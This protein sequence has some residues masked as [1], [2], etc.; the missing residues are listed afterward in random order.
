MSRRNYHCYL[1]PV[2]ATTIECDVLRNFTRCLAILYVGA[3]ALLIMGLIGI[4]VFLQ[5]CAFKVGGDGFCCIRYFIFFLSMI[6]LHCCNV[7][8][9]SCWYLVVGSFWIRWK[10]LSVINVSTFLEYSSAFMITIVFPLSAWTIISFSVTSFC[11]TFFILY[12]CLCEPVDYD[13]LPF[14]AN[15]Y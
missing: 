15:I 3:F 2:V 14:C 13:K 10:L 11:F 12:G 6:R 1:L 8:C 5:F 9:I 7:L 4:P